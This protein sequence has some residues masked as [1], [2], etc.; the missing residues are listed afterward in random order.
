ME[1]P[2]L[3]ALEF[4]SGIGA[5]AQACRSLDLDQPINIDVVRAFDQNHLA[6]AAYFANWQE[7]PCARNLDSIALAEL[8]EADL[9]WLSPPCTPY[10]RRGSRKDIEDNRSVSFLRLIEF[11]L[12]RRPRLILVENVEGFL[13]SKV[14]THLRSRLCDYCLSTVSLCSSQFGVPM[15]RPRV[16]VIASH[17]PL[18]APAGVARQALSSFLNAANDK[19]ERLLLSRE[20]QARY[21]PVLNAVDGSDPSSYSICFTSGYWRCRKAGGSMLKV[22]GRLRF[23]APDEIL[24]LLGFADC[25][26][27]GE[28]ISLPA[29]FR[30]VGNSVDVRVIRYLLTTLYMQGVL[31]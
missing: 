12:E 27:V 4:Y 13:E 17:Q 29:A 6:N 24:K 15:L 26:S 16:F 2:L 3:R 22:G 18:Q 10:S 11:M 19:D 1:P 5:F 14:F 23:F 21:E 9:W 20:E 8:P 7:Q 25:Y 31:N 28:N 30:L